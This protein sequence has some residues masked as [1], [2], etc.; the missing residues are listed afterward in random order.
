MGTKIVDLLAPCSIQCKNSQGKVLNTFKQVLV[1]GPTVQKVAFSS[2]L[3]KGVRVHTLRI[4]HA[5]IKH[6]FDST[7]MSSATIIL[8]MRQCC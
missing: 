6:L 7:E 8:V 1:L 2:S 5:V 3:K 4:P